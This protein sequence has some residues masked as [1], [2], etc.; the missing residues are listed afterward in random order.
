MVVLEDKE[1]ENVENDTEDHPMPFSGLLSL[2]H[3]D[4]EGE[5]DQAKKGK[6]ENELP[7][8]GGEEGSGNEQQP[9]DARFLRQPVKNQCSSEGENE[10]QQGSDCHG[11]FTLQAEILI[12]AEGSE[13]PGE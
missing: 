6:D 1:G 12:L 13:L 5:I 3:L 2:L 10:K 4:A 11:L 9:G 8:P 7:V